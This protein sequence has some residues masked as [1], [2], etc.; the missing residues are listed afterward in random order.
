[1]MKEH[2][3][4]LFKFNHWANETVV[5]FLLEKNIQEDK[6]LSIASHI[7]LA[8]E[9]WYWRT[10]GRQTDLPVWDLKTLNEI[11]EQTSASDQKWLDLISSMD[12]PGFEGILKYANMAGQPHMNT[13]QDVLTHVINHATYHRGQII[14]LIRD[15]GIK[16]PSTDY[17]RYARQFL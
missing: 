12:D 15:K 2:F 8:Q 10:V 13:V 4:K 14:Y 9:N 17:I 6:I 11:A 7:Y 1:M 16:P 3:Y 5:E